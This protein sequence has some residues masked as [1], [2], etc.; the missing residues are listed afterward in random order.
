MTAAVMR[1]TLR[2]DAG[3]R[4]RL[5]ELPDPDALRRFAAQVR[6]HAIANL[7]RLLS[8]LAGNVRRAGGRVH[9]ATDAREAQAMAVGLAREH[10]VRRV[11]KAKS[12]LSEE[13]GLN[14]ALQAAGIQ[15]TE[16]D[17]GQYIVQL[18]GSRAGHILAPV[19]HKS[20]A[21]IAR[22]FAEK[23][24]VRYSEDPPHL[25]AAARDVLR[26]RFRQADMGISGVNL[27]VAETGSILLLTNEGN[28]RF[29]TSWPRV[30]LAIMGM[31]R[32]VGS[33]R[34]LAV[35]LKLLARS[36]TGQ[37][38]GVYTSLITGPRRAG[39][40]DGPEAFELIIVDNGRS[41]ILADRAFR[42]VLR[43]IRCGACLNACPVFRSVGGLAYEAVYS[44]PIGKVIMPLLGPLGQY[45][46]LP[47]ASS[48]CGACLEACPVCIDIPEL[49]VRWRER[50]NRRE[51]SRWR[52]RWGFR[53]WS[54]VMASP[55]RYRWASRAGRW[56]F[57]SAWRDGWLHRLPGSLAGWSADRDLPAPAD[58][59]FHHRKGQ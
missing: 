15:V 39:D 30:H 4:E 47:S 48:L 34:D 51:V 26:A 33:L 19:I 38:M 55:R 56:F 24:G 53:L 59:P 1:G 40:L 25:A 23:L 31:E 13:I 35:I 14:A 46:P 50:L 8:E 52:A 9:W 49:L 6:Q 5:G 58:H 28:G 18:E 10:G 42:E 17:L 57:H 7:D 3:R 43:C 44:G 32:V 11:V 37:R 12:M 21:D 16:T 27:A 45:A 36:A 29:C 2:Q 20:R 54:W 22:L 41:R